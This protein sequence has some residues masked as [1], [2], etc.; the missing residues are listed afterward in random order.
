MTD[1]IND[2]KGNLRE[3]VPRH[4]RTPDESRLLNV[5]FSLPF[6][7]VRDLPPRSANLPI[8][9]GWMADVLTVVRD[10]VAA[11]ERGHL[12]KLNELDQ[13]KRDLKAAGRL[14]FFIRDN[15]VSLYPVV[16]TDLL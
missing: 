1:A 4:D 7:T 11:R 16:D 3:T 2:K 15:N 5:L 9:A 13:V 8:T 12:M 14:Q 6:L 10:A